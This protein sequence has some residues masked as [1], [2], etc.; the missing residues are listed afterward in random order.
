MQT[1]L[2]QSIIGGLSFL[3]LTGIAFSV[4]SSE[5]SVFEGEAAS[6]T[7]VILEAYGGGNNSGATYQHDY[8]VL[9][10]YSASS[11]TLTGWSFQQASAAGNTWAKVDLTGSIP[12]YGYYLIR[13][14]GYASGIPNGVAIPTAD[15]TSLINFGSSGKLALLNNTTALNSA[16]P[17][18]NANIIDFVGVGSTAGQ[19][20]GSNPTGNPS[21]TTSVQRKGLLIDTDNNGNDFEVTTP[22]PKNTSSTTGLSEATTFSSTFMT[23]TENKVGFCNDAG[24]D[25]QT[26]KT[27]YNSM[28]KAGKREFAL[29]SNSS[30]TEARNRYSYLIS[31]NASLDKFAT[32][33]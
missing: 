30:T 17:L 5:P 15:V 20:E 10:N 22:S 8:F 7:V 19:S 28:A 13:G 26:L 6:S 12:A 23:S 18:P 3:L 14:F 27:A 25:W 24:L 2:K 9:Y 29:N 33:S 32:L 31:F 11:I 21:N 1:L 16:T 4:G